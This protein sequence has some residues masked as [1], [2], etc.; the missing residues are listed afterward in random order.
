M[1]Q[2]KR[3]WEVEGADAFDCFILFVWDEGSSST[4]ALFLGIR[5]EVDFG[6][7]STSTW[8][9]DA[10]WSSTSALFLVVGGWWLLDTGGAKE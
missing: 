10:T 6:P 7:D 3:V 9:G 4:S 1:R 2:G 5:E 8:R